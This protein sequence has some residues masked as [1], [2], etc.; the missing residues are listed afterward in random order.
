MLIVLQFWQNTCFVTNNDLFTTKCVIGDS[1]NHGENKFVV[2][3]KIFT[4]KYFVG[5]YWNGCDENK[6][7][8]DYKVTT[9]KLFCQY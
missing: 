7:V 6:F 5:I 8:I 4:A 9:M 2:N 1:L 3:D